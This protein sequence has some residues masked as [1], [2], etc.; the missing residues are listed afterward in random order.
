MKKLLSVLLVL[1]MVLS[2]CACSKTSSGSNAGGAAGDTAGAGTTTAAAVSDGAGTFRVGY[3]KANITPDGQMGLSGYGRSDQRL[4]TGVLNY[5]YVTCVAITDADDNTILLYGM[6]L[7]TPGVAL[8]YVEDVSRATGVPVENIVMSASHTHSS[9]DYNLDLPTRA[10]ALNKVQTG[11]VKA[12]KTAM[13]DRKEAKMYGGSIETEGMNFVRH[14]LMNDGTYCGDNFG[15]TESGYKQHATEADS[16]LQLIKFTREGDN[17]IY[18]TNFQTHPHQ[19]GGSSKY[20][21][22]ADIV[23]EYRMHMENDL[24]CEVLYFSGAGGNINSHSRVKEEQATPDWKAWGK[25]MAEYAQ[26]VEFTELQTGKVQAS[27]TEFSAKIN[28]ADDAYA[29]I[30]GELR[31]RWNKGELTTAQVKELGAAQGIKLNSPYHAG[32][33]NSRASMADS[34]SF[35]I[36]A[37][38]FGSVGVVAFPGEQFDTNG[39]FI[40]ENS[41]FAMTIIAT[42]A[43]G[44]N[45]YFP[46][47]F[48]FDVSGGYECDTTKY[49]AG[50][51]ERLADQYVA[52]LTEQFGN[53]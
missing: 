45:G 47:Q 32:A 8:R 14:Y 31:S 48:A 25:K 27:T 13:E 21:L 37:F 23:G 12:A 51:A 34:N 30:C 15:S 6:D 4:S 36:S 17:D 44:E 40:K 1:T 53:K 2:L 18:L 33:I 28:H 49:V 16:E 29:A 41:P 5:L 9:P 38:S 35:V 43:N 19:T 20:D 7:G 10:D 24:G 52:M 22:S 42:K 3:G 11:V 50:T 46:S 26:K 39:V